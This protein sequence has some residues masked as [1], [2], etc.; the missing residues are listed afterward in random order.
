M[1]KISKHQ[2]PINTLKIL[3]RFYLGGSSTRDSSEIIK[4]YKKIANSTKSENY[5]KEFWIK[6]LWWLIANIRRLKK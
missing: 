6:A 5:Q 3:S 2:R 1:L 4:N